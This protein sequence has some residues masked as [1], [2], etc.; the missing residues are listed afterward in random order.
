MLQ[1]ENVLKEYEDWVKENSTSQKSQANVEE[2]KKEVE[3]PCES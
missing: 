1:A 2:I 3:S